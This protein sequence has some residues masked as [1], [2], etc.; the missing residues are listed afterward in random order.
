MLLRSLISLLLV[1]GL[2]NTTA[3]ATSASQLITGQ[4][5]EWY[6]D[7]QASSQVTKAYQP[8]QAQKVLGQGYNAVN[9]NQARMSANRLVSVKF[10]LQNQL[11][12]QETEHESLREVISLYPEE[13]SAS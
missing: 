3:A 1:F 10:K 7:L 11:H 5:V 9:F 6:N 13:D 4:Q 12:P 8:F 2:A